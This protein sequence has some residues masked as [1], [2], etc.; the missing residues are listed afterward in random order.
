M[1][2]LSDNQPYHLAISFTDVLLRHRLS[3]ADT[4]RL[5]VQIHWPR[6]CL[7]KVVHLTS[8]SRVSFLCF[9]HKKEH[10]RHCRL[11][12]EV[13][14]VKHWCERLTAIYFGLARLPAMV[15]TFSWRLL[16]FYCRSLLGAVRNITTVMST[17][18]TS[19][20]SCSFCCRKCPCCRTKTYLFIMW[21]CRASGWQYTHTSSLPWASS[22][23]SLYFYCWSSYTEDERKKMGLKDT[24]AAAPSTQTCLT[25]NCN[26]KTVLNAKASNFENT[27]RLSRVE[28]LIPAPQTTTRWMFLGTAQAW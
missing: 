17:S 23:I 5:C 2:L 26:Q 25:L 11:Q 10:R 6:R 8:T 3:T 16:E 24:I 28:G 22:W 14:V 15:V 9:L 20:L 19:I 1:Q 4:R 21:K 12:H 18:F 27:I 7:S 13:C